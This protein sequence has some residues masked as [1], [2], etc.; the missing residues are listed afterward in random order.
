M[1]TK[2]AIL[3][4][5]KLSENLE[6]D[7]FS[8]GQWE[9]DILTEIEEMGEVKGKHIE[10]FMANITFIDSHGINA[11]KQLQ[12]YV[13]KRDCKFTIIPPKNEQ[14]LK[15]LKKVNILN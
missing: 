5:S 12:R 10:L 2:E 9:D 11:L 4:G 13:E 6:L 7:L 15:L 3:I 14:V 1:I 8:S